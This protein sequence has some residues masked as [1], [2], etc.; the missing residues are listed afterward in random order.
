[1]SRRNVK[2]SASQ[3][4]GVVGEL[5]SFAY[6]TGHDE[7]DAVPPPLVM[8]PAKLSACLRSILDECRRLVQDSGR[9]LEV[10]EDNI[11]LRA[12]VEA[13]KREMSRLY[14]KLESESEPPPW[15]SEN[16]TNAPKAAPRPQANGSPVKEFR[17]PEDDYAEDSPG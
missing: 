8:P 12:D 15:E 1:M 6:F 7:P 16:K 17:Y 5:W 9:V 14:E 10:T 13:Y 11:R 4:T 2:L 3:A